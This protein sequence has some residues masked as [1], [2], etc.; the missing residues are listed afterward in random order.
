MSASIGFL[1]A[2]C[3]AAAPVLSGG[4][5]SLGE[6]G[7]KILSAVWDWWGAK[8]READRRRELEAVIKMTAEQ[9]KAAVHQAVAEH[10]A[11]ESER[12][13]AQLEAYL[14]ALQAQIRRASRR[15]SDPAGLTLSSKMALSRA[16]DLL[17][18]LPPRPPRFVPGEKVAGTDLELVALLGIGGFG[19]VWKARNLYLSSEPPV[20]LKFCLDPEAAAS[21]R[22]EAK[23]LD[24]IRREGRHPGIV[25]LHRTYLS[26]DPP[27]LEYEW[28][29][30]GDLGGFVLDRA[31]KSGVVSPDD[32]ARIVRRLAE[33][34]GFAHAKGIVHRDLKPAN[35]L[36]FAARRADGTPEVRFKVT[37]FGIGGITA[38]VA[39]RATGR[40]GTLTIAAALGS[41]TLHYA[42]PEQERGEAPDPRDDVHALGVIWYQMLVGDLTVPAPRGPGWKKRLAAQGVPAPQVELIEACVSSERADRPDTGEALAAEL[43]KGTAESVTVGEVLGEE[44]VPPPDPIP[45]PKPPSGV[46]GGPRPA[47]PP[48]PPIAEPLPVAPE[49][50]DPAGWPRYRALLAAL[51]GLRLDRNRLVWWRSWVGWFFGT[52]FALWAF[53]ALSGT[54]A[55][56]AEPRTVYYP[57]SSSYDYG[58]GYSSYSSQQSYTSYR[59][60]K[61]AAGVL[62]MLAVGTL[63]ADQVRAARR[64]RRNPNA[65][66]PIPPTGPLTYLAFVFGW[67]AVICM[68]GSAREWSPRGFIGPMMALGICGL[69][70][71]LFFARRVAVAR[72]RER[73]ITAPEAVRAEFGEE[74]DVVAPDIDL[75]NT[76]QVSAAIAAI[77]QA[78]MVPAEG[79]FARAWHR[80]YAPL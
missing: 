23:L 62:A 4:T 32:S 39:T 33:I 52:L 34:T 2:V 28:I 17:P 7:A 22:R 54:V 55:T 30:G 41:Y 31:R 3:R 74:L 21:L 66:P 18:L 44:S 47:P 49:L 60:T 69:L 79:F 13:Q 24:A 5:S 43:G 45:K 64:R 76:T 20:A 19:E 68:I 9:Y 11:G 70:A 53:T 46:K 35:V 57:S 58:Y 71:S 42:S 26:A 8:A 48:V 51:R 6:V 16:E 1:V 38:G 36:T 40:S 75:K 14:I 59:D 15:P 73:V 12:I 63:I 10:A 80:L 37:D 25:D 56:I 61:D 29:D 65:S 50:G 77:E 72:V 67:F 78:Y 27:F